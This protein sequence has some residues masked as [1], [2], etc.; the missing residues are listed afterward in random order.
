MDRYAVVGHPVEHSQSPFI[1]AA[2]AQATG[3]ALTYERLLAPLDG[4]AATLARFAAEGGRG[5]NVT[6]PFKAEACALAAR[7]SPRAARA[8]AANTLRREGD[9]WYAD[10]TDGIG[11][12]RDLERNAGFAIA[13]GPT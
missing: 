8:R 9:G 7:A 6:V 12:V 13:G 4:F 11:L 3:Q 10:N 2:F 5:C 1:H